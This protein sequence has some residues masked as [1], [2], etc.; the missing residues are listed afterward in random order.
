M[1]QWGRFNCYMDET[2]EGRGGRSQKGEKMA[3]MRR[4]VV[5]FAI[6]IV[7]AGATGCAA[8]RHVEGEDEG[9]R[10]RGYGFGIGTRF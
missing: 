10:S 1:K 2:I 3:L 8:P 6:L 9:G 5:A 7:L 4:P